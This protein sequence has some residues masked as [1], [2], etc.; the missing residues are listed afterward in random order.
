MK[1]THKCKLMYMYMCC[2]NTLSS[3]QVNLNS[4]YFTTF[5][6]NVFIFPTYCSLWDHPMKMTIRLVKIYQHPPPPPPSP[7][8]VKRITRNAYVRAPD[9]FQLI[10]I[11]SKLNILFESFQW[12]SLAGGITDI[13]W[14]DAVIQVNLFLFRPSIYLKN[15]TFN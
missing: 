9:T 14:D 4:K 1:N 10:E 15:H 6:N 13:A 5:S 11:A 3:L 8:L 12:K 2:I 7:L